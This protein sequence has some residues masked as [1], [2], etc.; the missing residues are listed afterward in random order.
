MG[1]AEEGGG[2]RRLS[3]TPSMRQRGSVANTKL[4]AG[5]KTVGRLDVVTDD[6]GHEVI[7]EAREDSEQTQRYK[8]IIDLLVAA[9]YFRARIQ[10]R[11]GQ[12]FLHFLPTL[13]I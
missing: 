6:R 11:S 9:G 13:P 12:T 5:V 3:H 7:V 2:A 10:V 4:F 1:T 8:E